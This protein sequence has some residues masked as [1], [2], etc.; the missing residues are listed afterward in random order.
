MRKFTLTL[1]SQYSKEWKRKESLKVWRKTVNEILSVK[2]KFINLKLGSLGQKNQEEIKKMVKAHQHSL[3]TINISFCYIETQLFSDILSCAEN[4][5]SL[6]ISNGTVATTSDN[7][8]TTKN[9]KNLQHLMV[10]GLSCWL[11]LSKISQLL[12]AFRLQLENP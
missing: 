10:S 11:I 3:R 4:L 7:E 6:K 8:I 12:F 5:E 1:K 9:M 2:R